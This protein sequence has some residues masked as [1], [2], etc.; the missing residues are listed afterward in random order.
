MDELITRVFEDTDQAH[1]AHL[2][3]ESYAQ[4]AA[5]SDF[6]SEARAKLDKLAEAAMGLD[7]PPPAA[8]EVP[9]VEQIESGLL[10]LTE[11]RDSVCQNSPILENIY[12]E[13]CGTYVAALYKLKRL[14]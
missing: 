13:L 11:M 7:V 14:K 3:T 5:L 12:D 1:I 4:H 8:P 9:I 2:S 10:E 6:Y